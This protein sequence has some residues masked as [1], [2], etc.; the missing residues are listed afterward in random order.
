ME[1][2]AIVRNKTFLLVELPAGKRAVRYC[3]VFTQ[4]FC[5]DGSVGMAKLVA[6]GSSRIEGIN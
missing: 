5:P 6:E 1:L 2:A 3:W 4:K